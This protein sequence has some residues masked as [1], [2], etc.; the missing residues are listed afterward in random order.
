MEGVTFYFDAEVALMEWLQGFMG[1]VMTPLMSLIT[2]LGEEAVAVGVLGFLYWVWDKDT[3]VFVG[4]NVLVGTVVNPFLKNFALRRRPY[5][6]HPQIQCLKPVHDG[7]IYDI[8]AQGYSF[9][10]GHSSNSVIL[11]GS[12]AQTLHR[13]PLTVFAIAAPLLVGFSRVMLGVHYPT[14]VLA[15]WASGTIVIAVMSAVQRRVKHKERMY[16]VIAVVFLPGFFICRTND[17]YTCYGILCGFFAARILDE[18]IVHFENTRNA[19]AAVLRLAIGLA[20]YFGLNTLLKAPFPEEFLQSATTG[21]F[22]FRAVRYGLVSFL[23]LGVYPASF[24]KVK[25]LS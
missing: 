25:Q 6:D 13:R 7:D 23:M 16:L 8:S 12:L 4:T 18:R 21:Q 1:S 19:R 14:D 3:A 9:P 17:F 10:S 15:G 2:L 22:L 20:C 5:F 11:Y 24:G